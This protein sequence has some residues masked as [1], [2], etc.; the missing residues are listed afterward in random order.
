MKSQSITFLRILAIALV[1]IG[2]TA[3]WLVLGSAMLVRTN[4]RGAELG[5]AVDRVWGSPLTQRHPTAWYLSPAGEKGRKSLQPASSSVEV[6]L[7]YEPKAKGLLWHR[8]YTVQFRG[9][10]RI[11]NPTPIPQTIYV[12]F[13]LPSGDSEL[14]AAAFELGEG[15][16]AVTATAPVDGALTQAVVVP[17]G[18]S[19]PLTVTYRTRGRDLWTYS[20]GNAGRLRDF[21]LNLATDFREIDFPAGTSSPSQREAVE[22]GWRLQWQYEDVIDPRAIGMAMPKVLNAGPIAARMSF[23]APVSLLFFFAVLLILGAVRGVSLH[24]MNYFFLAAGCFAFQL[25]FAYLVDHLDVYPSF[26]IAAAVS[27]ALVCG[28]VQLVGGRRLLTIALP[29]QVAF[30]VLFSAS[31]FLDGFTGLTITAGAIITLAIL[32]VASARVDWGEKFRR[33][34]PAPAA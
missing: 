31:F 4:D 18:G 27:I 16:D 32:M 34:K 30:M 1:F 5:A 29:A 20:F 33:S 22:D 8:T 11:A 10:Y 7:G 3:A 21:R 26:A 12:R 19:V 13:E 24:P 6:L 23:F 28:Y 25:L 9:A 15:G 2:A 14:E 17:A